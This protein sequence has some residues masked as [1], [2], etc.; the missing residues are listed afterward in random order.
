MAD[1]PVP[2]IVNQNVP[3][4]EA[5]VWK[6]GFVWSASVWKVIPHLK[7]SKVI[8]QGPPPGTLAPHGTTIHAWIEMAPAGP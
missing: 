2:N 4:A 5:L 3:N 7:E 8:Y 6:A 1:V